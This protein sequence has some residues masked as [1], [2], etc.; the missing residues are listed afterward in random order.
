MAT[1][2]WLWWPLKSHH[3]RPS[4]TPPL[5]LIQE[6]LFHLLA[7]LLDL[8]KL[9][10]ASAEVR[11]VSRAH[12]AYEYQKANGPRRGRY[13]QLRSAILGCQRSV[14]RLEAV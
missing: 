4:A 10:F 6:A 5:D 12:S 8:L 2:A 3:G 9:D 1:E 14:L 11:A 7:D 13:S